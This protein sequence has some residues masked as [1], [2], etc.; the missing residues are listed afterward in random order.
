ML[1]KIFL[2]PARIFIRLYFR[3]III[4]KKNLLSLEGPLLI[5]SN[6]PNSFLDAI[7]L[8]TLFKH[9]VYSLTRGDVFV[10]PFLTRIL[11][12]FNMLPVYRISEGAKNLEHNYTT[13][14]VCRNIFKQNGIVLIFSEARSVNEWHLRPLRKGTA[15]LAISA[16]ENG[17]DL[18][19]LPAGINYSSFRTLGKKIV[20]NFGDLILKKDITEKE[21]QGKAIN[22][23]NTKL[24]YELSRLVLET[25]DNDKALLRN[26]FH[27]HQTL[28]KKIILFLPATAG[29][30]F[31]APLYYLIHFIIKDKATDHYDS[32]ML[33][34][35]F[36]VYPFYITAITLIAYFFTKNILALFLLMIIPLAALAYIKLKNK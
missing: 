1:Y 26:Y 7:I 2:L 24:R 29:Y 15:R 34:V 4:N 16:W 5:A 32:I 27:D 3:K 8:G 14:N 17:I 19:I 31:N 9:P 33:G 12:S 20:L 30:I 21:N 23:F 18:K 25:S 13:F 22:E 35:L 28:F 6:H 11:S 10:N 36:F